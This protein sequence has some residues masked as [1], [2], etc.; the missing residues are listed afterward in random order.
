MFLGYASSSSGAGLY[1]S[2]TYQGQNY[3]SKYPYSNQY[4]GYAGGSTG[5]F[6]QAP[7]A[8]PFEFQNAFQQYFN[9][10]SALNAK[11]EEAGLKIFIQI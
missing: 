9:Q 7:F 3:G 1:N 10:L 8:S 11:Y 4:T 6:P 5:Y 2:N